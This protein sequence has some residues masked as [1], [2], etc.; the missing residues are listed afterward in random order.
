[1]TMTI[2][3]LA[4]WFS[5]ENSVESNHSLTVLRRR[6][7]MASAGFSGSSIRI[8]SAPRPVSTPPT[9]VA[10]RNPPLVVASSRNGGRGEASLAGNS[11]RY[12]GA[13][14]SARQS[15]ANLSESSRP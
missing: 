6:W 12:Q 15:R 3:P 2:D 11:A 9:E 7:L 10:M 14:I 4:L 5:R 8:T 13:V 1:M